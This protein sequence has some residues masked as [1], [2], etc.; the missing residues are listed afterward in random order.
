MRVH[1]AIGRY[2][3]LGGAMVSIDVGAYIGVISLAM[4]RFGGPE[5]TVHSFEADDLNFGRLRQNVANGPG[6]S[7]RIYN[8][9]V[10]N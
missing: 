5:H 6:S 3:R 10:G 4:A 9:A 8:T 1:G 7:I 2:R